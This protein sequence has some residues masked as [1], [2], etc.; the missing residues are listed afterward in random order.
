M[1]N[2]FVVVN[3][4][5]TSVDTAKKMIEEIEESKGIDVIG[6]DMGDMLCVSDHENLEPLI[7]II[8]DIVH[9]H[10]NGMWCEVKEVTEESIQ[11]LL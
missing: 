3:W 10:N 6:A 2:K 8:T 1:A 5:N 9:K 11:H 4:E 7:N